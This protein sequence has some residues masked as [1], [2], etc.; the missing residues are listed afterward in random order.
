MQKRELP[1]PIQGFGG[2]ET[3]QRRNNKDDDGTGNRTE[4][5]VGTQTCNATKEG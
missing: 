3:V 5:G 2:R 4:D 1:Y